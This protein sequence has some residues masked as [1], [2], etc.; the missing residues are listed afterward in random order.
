MI[1]KVR[2]LKKKDEL[3]WLVGNKADLSEER[4]ISSEEGGAKARELCVMYWEVSA[5]EATNVKEMV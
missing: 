2:E 3:I 4:E 1:W 5:K